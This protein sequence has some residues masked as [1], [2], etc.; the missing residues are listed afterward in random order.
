MISALRPFSILPT[1]LTT[2]KATRDAAAKVAYNIRKKGVRH[3]AV[4]CA[5]C[6][7]CPDQT[8][9][10]IKAVFSE[11]VLCSDCFQVG[12]TLW[13]KWRSGANFNKTVC[14]KYQGP[15][16][17][18]WTGSIDATLDYYADP[19][20]GS[21]NVNGTISSWGVQLVRT[22]GWDL[23]I[24]SQAGVGSGFV[25]YAPS[26]TSGGAD[27]CLT[28]LTV[29]NTIASADCGNWFFHGDLAGDGLCLMTPKGCNG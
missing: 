1:W 13:A 24:G 3:T 16:P 5:D 11:I 9:C 17:C 15:G 4:A 21:G 22:G 8:P 26:I 23:R 2:G 29:I 18:T 20:C 10:Y 12:E 28:E 19:A 25:F 6:C 14:L 27:Q 7:G